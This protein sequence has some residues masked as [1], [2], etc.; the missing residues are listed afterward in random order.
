MPA[1]AKRAS[2]ASE[3]PP[4]SAITPLISPCSAKT[5]SVFSGMVSMVSGAARASTYKVSEALGS[6]VPVLP[7]S[8]RCGRARDLDVQIG[9]LGLAVDARGG[10]DAA[11]GV[12]REQRR[13]FHRYPA[14]DAVG[15]VEDRTEQIGSSAQ[16]FE[17]QLHEQRFTGLSRLCL[18]A[19]A[20]VVGGAVADRLVENGRVRGQPR[21]REL[22]HV[23][24][25]SAI[26]EDLTGNVVQ[27]ETLAEVMQL[28]GLVHVRSWCV[29]AKPSV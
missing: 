10:V 29:A 4:S 11:R 14:V 23:A 8:R 28:L 26:V 21:D 19:D 17:R 5:R 27:P 9:A 25:Q 3:S 20:V 7:Q 2:T 16:I 22:V 12:A 1:L 24:A 18:V 15:G 6:L 13:H